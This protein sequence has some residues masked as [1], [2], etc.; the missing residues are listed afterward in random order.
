MMGCAKGRSYD[1]WAMF[2]PHMAPIGILQ[3]ACHAPSTPK[4][5]KTTTNSI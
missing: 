5:K 4:C 2:M 3:H 1:A